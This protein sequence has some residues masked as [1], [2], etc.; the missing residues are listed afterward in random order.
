MLQQC[1][2]INLGQI[3]VYPVPNSTEVEIRG[4]R[5]TL[6][7]EFSDFRILTKFS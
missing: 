6:T 4:L 1:N 7:Y 2:V 3:F 5:I